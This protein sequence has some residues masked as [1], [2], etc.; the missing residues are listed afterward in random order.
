[1]SADPAQVVRVQ[2]SRL[3]QAVHS[4]PVRVV[5]LLPARPKRARTR[6]AAAERAQVRVARAVP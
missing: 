2:R 6:A 5:Q 1:M 3:A 4:L